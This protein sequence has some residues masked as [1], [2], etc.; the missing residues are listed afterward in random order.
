[1]RLNG[2]Q[3]HVRRSA[4]ARSSTLTLS[5]LEFR[6]EKGEVDTILV[7]FVDVQGRLQGKRVVAGHFMSEVMHAG[8]A[9]PA[10]TCWPSTRA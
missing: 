6:I 5:D 7:G 10:P 9:I 8:T 4:W 2:P 1:M 3:E